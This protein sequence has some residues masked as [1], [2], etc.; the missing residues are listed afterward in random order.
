MRRTL[1]YNL[2]CKIC[3]I[4]FNSVMPFSKYCGRRCKRKADYLSSYVPH[5]HVLTFITCS[6]C[7]KK[8]KK[9]PSSINYSKSGKLYCNKSCKAKSEFKK[10]QIKCYCHSCGKEMS[11]SPSLIRGNIFCSR[12]CF[13]QNLIKSGILV[14]ANIERYLWQKEY[15]KNLW[16]DEKYREK[17]TQMANKL[18]EDPFYIDKVMRARK[19]TPNKAEGKIESILNNLYPNKWKFVGDGQFSIGRKI[20][21]FVNINGKKLIIDLFG[22]YWHRK[23]EEE[24]RIN[25]FKDFGYKTLILWDNE[26]KIEENVKNKI[27]DFVEGG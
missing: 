13:G 8:V 7:G 20:P 27:I 18:W 11:R 3:G 16:R 24:K 1:G 2:I 14:K 26:L 23:E 22:T 19:I 12:K 25:C 5:P 17:M 4:S 15:Y 9:R 6:Y 21:D 10:D